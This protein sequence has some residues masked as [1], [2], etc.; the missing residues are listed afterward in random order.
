MKFKFLFLLLFIMVAAGSYGQQPEKR[1]IRVADTLT[2]QEKANRNRV[3]LR[4]ELDSLIKLYSPNQTEVKLK[5][6]DKPQKLE[7]PPFFFLITGAG[8]L[9]IG[10][11]LYLLFNNQKK[12]HRA[13]HKLNRQ[14]AEMEYAGIWGGT[15]SGRSKASQNL[16]KKIAGMHDE[17]GKLQARNNI[18][19]QSAKEYG[20]MKQEYESMRQQ[21]MDVYKM[22]NYPGYDS[23]GTET[24]MVK[25]ML[26]TEKSVAAY[27]YERF[28]KPVLA[29]ADANKNN[30]AK[31]PDE[32]SEK[33]LQLLVSLSL[34]YIEYL[35]LRINDLSIGGKM[36]QR[37]QGL[38]QGNGLDPALMKELN[39]EHGSRALVLRIVLDTIPVRRLSYPV[40]DETNLNL[41]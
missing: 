13:F 24:D 14:L 20:L 16:E 7:F 4:S 11:L 18:L 9:V 37:I 26:E 27:G 23:S 17:L 29:I 21:I 28:M 8:L 35:Y 39:T 31:I 41:S 2:A 30:P 5:E 22:K 10:L 25:G 15:M 38:S 12:T 34:F 6:P 36:V 3:I 1:N 19:E 33:L 32:E 40:F